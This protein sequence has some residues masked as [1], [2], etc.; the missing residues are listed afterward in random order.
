MVERYIQLIGC[1]FVDEVVPYITE[2][3]LDVILQAFLIDLRILGDKNK[4]FT[5]K[6]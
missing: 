2:Q 3:D 4:N 5:V 6:E 1:K